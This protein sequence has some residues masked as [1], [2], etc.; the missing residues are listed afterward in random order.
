MNV[1]LSKKK[2]I[3]ETSVIVAFIESKLE[4][5]PARFTRD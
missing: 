3:I 1:L 5:E 2:T 4:K